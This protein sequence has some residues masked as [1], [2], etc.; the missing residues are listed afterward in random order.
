MYSS[1]PHSL[2][3]LSF[4]LSGNFQKVEGVNVAGIGLQLR[5]LSDYEG[6]RPM[7]DEGSTGGGQGRHRIFLAKYDG[8]TVVLKGYALVS[9]VSTFWRARR[10]RGQL[11]SHP[12]AHCFDLVRFEFLMLDSEVGALHKALCR[13]RRKPGASPVVWCA[14]AAFVRVSWGDSNA[15]ASGG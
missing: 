3:F 1:I 2:K 4:L 13:P 8:E 7:A 9:T 11:E 15:C 6:L 5:R 14:T 10:C 12:L